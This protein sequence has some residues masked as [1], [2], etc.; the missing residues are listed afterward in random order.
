MPAQQFFGLKK[1]F[2]ASFWPALFSALFFAVLPPAFALPLFFGAL[3][4]AIDKLLY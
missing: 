4:F 3:S 2:S 1:S